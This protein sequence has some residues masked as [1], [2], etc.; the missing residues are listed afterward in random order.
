M[1]CWPMRSELG[2]QHCS[3]SPSSSSSPHKNPRSRWHR[4]LFPVHVVLS[5]GVLSRCSLGGGLAL[6]WVCRGSF[7]VWHNRAGFSEPS[8]AEFTCLQ[9]GSRQI[10][11]LHEVQRCLLCSV[12]PECSC[13]LTTCAFLPLSPSPFPLLLLLLSSIFSS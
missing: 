1:S 11:W 2:K 6:T 4:S 7:C 5:G 12:L 9:G 8:K 10:S 3:H 13:L